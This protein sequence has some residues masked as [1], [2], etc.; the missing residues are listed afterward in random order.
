[1][2]L[3]LFYLYKLSRSTQVI[4]IYKCTKICLHQFVE[5]FRVQK[6]H[7]NTETYSTTV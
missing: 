5:A 1:M 3:D 2:D 7:I 4:N 6:W